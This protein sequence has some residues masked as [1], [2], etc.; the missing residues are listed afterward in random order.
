MRR[1]MV[2]VHAVLFAWFAPLAAIGIQPAEPEH[3]LLPAMWEQYKHYHSAAIARGEWVVTTEGEI[4]VETNTKHGAPIDKSTLTH[5]APTGNASLNH[6]DP[7]GKPNLNYSAP[8][9]KVSLNHGDPTGKPNLKHSAP[10]SKASLKHSDPTGEPNLK[11]SAP[12]SIASL[13]HSA[14]TSK[15]SLN[16]SDPPGKTNLKHSAPTSIASLKHSAPTGKASLN[17]SDPTGEPNLKHSAP[18]SKASLNHE[19]PK[20][21]PKLKRSATTETIQQALMAYRHFIQGLPSQKNDGFF[22]KVH[23][24]DL[25][26]MCKAMYHEGK[27]SS[28]DN[29]TETSL[30]VANQTLDRVTSTIHWTE[31]KREWEIKQGLRRKLRATNWAGDLKILDDTRVA[32]NEDVRCE[33]DGDIWWDTCA[34]QPCMNNMKGIDSSCKYRVAPQTVNPLGGD[35]KG[36]I[37][38]AF[39]HLTSYVDRGD[40]TD[41][42]M[43]SDQE[44]MANVSLLPLEFQVAVLAG[45]Y[46]PAYVYMHA[47]CGAGVDHRTISLQCHFPAKQ[48]CLLTGA[49]AHVRT[50]GKL[51]CEPC[52]WT[53]KTPSDKALSSNATPALLAKG[54]AVYVPSND[55]LDTILPQECV[56]D[57]DT[58]YKDLKFKT[59]SCDSPI[60]IANRAVAQPWR[61]PE[62]WWKG[63][64]GHQKQTNSTAIEKTKETDTDVSQA[65]FDS[66]DLPDDEGEGESAASDSEG[67]HDDDEDDEAK[68]FSSSSS[69]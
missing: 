24:Y 63:K 27:C 69:S 66:S 17:H 7:T 20:H 65:K 43:H 23:G 45:H 47:H 50:C 18:T 44:L 55:L 38:H 40:L 58:D 12:T 5:G 59:S 22:S 39:K 56:Q 3:T 32:M 67:P 46:Y 48:W 2:A 19:A 49:V 33:D 61:V 29:A 21:K 16:H 54:P 51:F 26:T 11:H 10:T 13:K 42:K 41:G 68:A 6:S 8:T 64:G 1:G 9:S 35:S 34:K 25:C 31:A 60:R 14:P 53:C 37:A 4:H 30:Q 52:L 28:A 62:E 15:A 57:P 36:A